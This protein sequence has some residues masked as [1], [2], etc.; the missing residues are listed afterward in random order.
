MRPFIG[1]PSSLDGGRSQ[2]AAARGNRSGDD[3]SP[4]HNGLW[5]NHLVHLIVDGNTACT[6]PPFVLDILH[7]GTDFCTLS[8]LPAPKRLKPS[9][10]LPPRSGGGQVMDAIEHSSSANMAQAASIDDGSPTT[11]FRLHNCHHKGA[12]LIAADEEPSQHHGHGHMGSMRRSHRR[13]L[14]DSHRGGYGALPEDAAAPSHHG[15]DQTD[16]GTTAAMRASGWIHLLGARLTESGFDVLNNPI[17]RDAIGDAAAA[18][19]SMGDS[20]GD[21]ANGGH[22]RGESPQVAALGGPR[23]GGR[24]ELLPNLLCLAVPNHV[25]HLRPRSLAHEAFIVAQLSK[26]IHVAHR[27]V[28]ASKQLTLHVGI[29]IDGRSLLQKGHDSSGEGGR[30]SGGEARDDGDDDDQGAEEA[31]EPLSENDDEI[32][33]GGAEKSRRRRNR[34]MGAA[35]ITNQGLMKACVVLCEGGEMAKLQLGRTGGASRSATTGTGRGVGGADQSGTALH[36]NDQQD[37]ESPGSGIG[38]DIFASVLGQQLARKNGVVGKDLADFPVSGALQAAAAAFSGGAGDNGGASSSQGGSAPVNLPQTLGGF[39]GGY[40]TYVTFYDMTTAT[41]KDELYLVVPFAFASTLHVAVAFQHAV[42]GRVACPAALQGVP[43]STL[44]GLHRTAATKL[45][46]PL[47]SMGSSHPCGVLSLYWSPMVQPV[48]SMEISGKNI[49]RKNFVVCD[50]FLNV[51]VKLVKEGPGGATPHR[52]NVP[53]SCSPAA[54]AQR[55]LVSAA[56]KLDDRDH[57]REAHHNSP[58][59]QDNCRLAQTTPPVLP[60]RPQSAKTSGSARPAVGTTTTTTATARDELQRRCQEEGI[61]QRAVYDVVH[62]S[63]AYRNAFR[64]SFRPFKFLFPAKLLCNLSTRHDD[65]DSFDDEIQRDGAPRDTIMMGQKKP[66]TRQ[67]HGGSAAGEQ[68][69]GRSDV[70]VVARASIDRSASVCNVFGCLSQTVGQLASSHGRRSSHVGGMNGQS[71]GGGDGA[72][73]RPSPLTPFCSNIGGLRFAPSTSSVSGIIVNPRHHSYSDNR[74]I[75]AASRP[76]SAASL[77]RSKQLTDAAAQF[78]NESLAMAADGGPGGEGV[79]LLQTPPWDSSHR[80]GILH[81]SG[82]FASHILPPVTAAELWVAAQPPPKVGFQ[83]GAAGSRGMAD[84]RPGATDDDETHPCQPLVAPELLGVLEAMGTSWEGRRSGRGGKGPFSP[85]ANQGGT[86]Y[87]GY[88]S[89]HIAAALP[90][91]TA[92]ERIRIDVM[93]AQYSVGVLT[94]PTNTTGHHHQATGAGGT[95]GKEG[96]CPAARVEELVSPALLGTVELPLAALPFASSSS[97]ASSLLSTERTHDG[98]AYCTVSNGCAP[99]SSK[100][101]SNNTSSST[102][103]VTTTAFRVERHATFDDLAMTRKRQAYR[104]DPSSSQGRGGAAAAAIEFV[105]FAPTP[106]RCDIVNFQVNPLTIARRRVADGAELYGASPQSRRSMEPSP[107]GGIPPPHSIQVPA[108]T[109]TIRRP[110]ISEMVQFADFVSPVEIVSSRSDAST[111]RRKQTSLSRRRARQQRAKPH[112][113][114]SGAAGNSDSPRKPPF[115][116]AGERTSHPSA[117]VAFSGAI[118]IDCRSQAFYAHRTQSFANGWNLFHGTVVAINKLLWPFLPR[119][120]MDLYGAGVVAPQNQFSTYPLFRHP[121]HRSGFVVDELAFLRGGAECFS[122]SSATSTDIH[123]NDTTAREEAGNRT[124]QHYD[125]TGEATLAAYEQRRQTITRSA[126]SAM[127]LFLCNMI[128]RMALRADALS[129]YQQKDGGRGGAGGQPTTRGGRRDDDDTEEHITSAPTKA[130]ATPSGGITSGDTSENLHQLPSMTTALFQVFVFVITAVDVADVAAAAQLLDALVGLPMAWLFVVIPSPAPASSS[131]SPGQHA[132]D[133][134][135]SSSSKSLLGPSS[136]SS[137]SSS[138]LRDLQYHFRGKQNV[139]VIPLC[140]PVCGFKDLHLAFERLQRQ[141]MWRIPDMFLSFVRKSSTRQFETLCRGTFHGAS[142]A[143]TADC[144]RTA[145][146]AAGVVKDDERVGDGEK[147]ESASST[148]SSDGTGSRPRRTHPIE[149]PTASEA[150][151]II[152]A[153]RQVVSS[154]RDDFATSQDQFLK[155]FGLSKHESVAVVPCRRRPP[156]TPSDDL[157]GCAANPGDI[158]A[159]ALSTSL[160]RHRLKGTTIGPGGRRVEPSVFGSSFSVQ[161]SDRCGPMLSSASSGIRRRS[162]EN[163]GGAESTDD[164]TPSISEGDDTSDDDDVCVYDAA[165]DVRVPFIDLSTSSKKRNECSRSDKVADNQASD[166]DL[167]AASSSAVGAPGGDLQSGATSS[168]RRS[169]RA[170]A[171][172]A[173][174]PKARGKRLAM[175][176]GGEDVYLSDVVKIANP[177]AGD[178][179]AAT[180]EGVFHHSHVGP[181]AARRPFSVDNTTLTLV[182]I[183]MTEDQLMRRHMQ[184]E[185]DMYRQNRDWMAQQQQQRQTGGGDSTKTDEDASAAPAS[186]DMAGGGGGPSSL[187][188]AHASLL[189]RHF[190]KL[191]AATAIEQ[192]DGADGEDKGG[193]KNTLQTDPSAAVDALLDDTADTER[194]ELLRRLHRSNSVLAPKGSSVNNKAAPGEHSSHE[195]EPPLSAAGGGGRRGG[196]SSLGD[197]NA[198]GAY[199]SRRGSQAPAESR[200]PLPPTAP[201]P[202]GGGPTTATTLTSAK[203]HVELREAL[204][205][206]E[207]VTER[208]STSAKYRALQQS[209]QQHST[210]PMPTPPHIASEPPLRRYA[211][212]MVRS[213]VPFAALRLHAEHR[214]NASRQALARRR[215]GT[216]SREE[217]LAG[218][219]HGESAENRFVTDDGDWDT[220]QRG[221]GGAAQHNAKGAAGDVAQRVAAQHVS[222]RHGVVFQGGGWADAPPTFVYDALQRAARMVPRPQGS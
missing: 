182:D 30:K 140:N 29:H 205:A 131:P 130:S 50:P 179:A 153:A 6:E 36:H 204:K 5:P 32:E 149:P 85:G 211:T 69:G 44:I 199:P 198:E 197:F 62:V 222:E 141:L 70:V 22:V 169:T 64:V 105:S 76:S 176:V 59:R 148:S 134:Q 155:T 4:Y 216:A 158:A 37:D 107:R 28:G 13:G 152:P 16:A 109:L 154:Q 123:H 12:D 170:P 150:N 127:P 118:V 99:R 46:L 159:D 200:Q 221:G 74:I 114:K 108:T 147:D 113:Q 87:D 104:L 189:K 218:R 172:A 78:I 65:D 98:G 195:E 60:L 133:Q 136:P 125:T 132:D 9:W 95:S 178:G 156:P 164:V 91:L 80:G 106:K 66:Q 14:A 100:P 122:F 110:V 94:T 193:L 40:G 187:A 139:A 38:A 23:G 168:P 119:G 34:P 129:T 1:V 151:N 3:P 145:V 192:H 191:T 26:W 180:T 83:S 171:A 128:R 214:Q 103:A 126:S 75:A 186:A 97:S 201:H 166:L 111:T 90:V 207:E 79:R 185:R 43:L 72:V 212:K 11:I 10:H 77:G 88:V 165:N 188:D 203:L 135:Q 33:Q 177:P 137:S 48:G 15:G 213:A 55:P 53:D 20:S 121:D 142:S 124:L 52:K 181:S 8:Y 162:T 89:R 63:E 146:V 57:A 86:F 194:N 117:A 73:R 138:A 219:R 31:E 56:T 175:M 208:K 67:Q 143:A 93:D 84:D 161:K 144:R 120:G 96:H 49:F 21:V 7:L 217:T 115:N 167:P 39:I 160:P 184:L 174:A 206:Y 101:F 196:A 215:G 35:G 45:Q 183:F 116:V 92:A 41:Q 24:E 190:D 51:R 58:S 47:V 102:V 54:S 2:A 42:L 173:A 82:I 210:V 17:F 68:S 220:P 202:R 19:Q 112:H 61:F 18:E 209:Y 163:E 71:S 27:D 25:Y 157:S 81:F